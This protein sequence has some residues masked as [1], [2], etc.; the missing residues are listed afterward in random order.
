MNY[1]L[2][3]CHNDQETLALLE[4][5]RLSAPKLAE[6]RAQLLRA[7]A[8]AEF[9]Y[10]AWS[11]ASGGTRRVATAVARKGA[12]LADSFAR[13]ALDASERR[14]DAYLAKATDTAELEQRVRAWQAR[15]YVIR[16]AGLRGK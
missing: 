15:W 8:M 5:V 4:K 7:E 6:A 3:K 11:L 9:L 16:S 2:R 14:R 13:S 12:A 10:G 1:K